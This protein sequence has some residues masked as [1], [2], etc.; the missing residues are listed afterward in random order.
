MRVGT[1]LAFGFLLLLLGRQ[2]SAAQS[3]GAPSRVISLNGEWQ[4]ALAH[5]PAEGEGMAHFYEPSF[6]AQAFRPIPVPSNWSLHGFEEPLY[7]QQYRENGVGHL[8]LPLD[9]EGFY[10]HRFTVPADIAKRR[11]VLHF[12]GV[13]DSAEVWLNGQPLGRHDSG[14][15]G[16]QFDIGNQLRP[17]AENTLAVRVRQRTKDSQLDI[18]DDWVL[19]GIFRDVTLEFTPSEGYIQRIETTTK[20]DHDYRDAVLNLRLFFGRLTNDPHPYQAHVTLADPSGHEVAHA[21]LAGAIQLCG[22]IVCGQDVPVAMPVTAPLHWTAETPNL[23]T[24]RVDLLLDGQVVHTR[25]EQVGFREVSWAGGVL[26]VNGQAIKIRGVG[27]H[28]EHPDVGRATTR[29]QWLQ[30]I[31]MMKAGNINAVRTTHYPPAEGFVKLCDEMGLYVLE[32]IPLGFGGDLLLDES[33]AGPVLLRAR[34][35]LRRDVNRP[36]VIMW[37]LGNEDPLTDIHLTAARYIKG[38][39]PT[40][41]VLMPWRADETLPV[42]LDIRAPHYK[43]AEEYDRMAAASDRPVVSTEYSHAL[44]DHDFGGLADRWEAITRHAAGAGG[45]IW[46]WQDQG[47]RRNTVGKT[48]LDPV[49]D[50]G[51]YLAVGSEFVRHDQLGPDQI[52]DSHGVFGSDGIVNPDRT[53][54]RDYWETK[55]VYAPVRVMAEELPFRPGQAFAPISIR[56]DYDFTDLHAVAIHWQVMQDDRELS[57]G[58][59]H[60]DAPPHTV[61]VLQ[62]PLAAM[63]G[64]EPGAYSI[65][66]SFRHPDGTEITARSVHLRTPPRAVPVASGQR[67]RVVTDGPAVTVSAGNV[68]YRFDARTGQLGGIAAGGTPLVTGARLSIWRPLSFSETRLFR[69]GD[70]KQLPLVPD[71]GRYQASARSWTVTEADDG[72]HIAADLEQR[73]DDRNGFAARVDYHVDGDGALHVGYVITPHIE[74]KWLPEVGLRLDPAPGLDAMRWAGLGP[75][76]SYPDEHAAAR[77]GIWSARQGTEDAAGVKSGVE[78]AELKAASGPSLRITGA[79]YV[80]LDRV[81]DGAGALHVLSSMVGRS[82]KFKRPERLEDRLDLSEGSSFTGGFTVSVGR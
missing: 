59:A 4:F 6:D 50:L 35:V 52:M 55:A 61:G 79:P 63:G 15:T 21:E 14:F 60:V 32:E 27:R 25:T 9:S 34:E 24:L 7:T 10:L 78:W 40:R 56:N 57:A 8:P 46:H 42:E 38:A 58:D 67:P 36:S 45:F 22:F 1:C 77:F 81:S 68:S 29:E 39:D 49:A 47:L 48:V 70:D 30:D 75:I 43:T 54:Q 17:G 3:E 74:F 33:L 72:V 18:N 80:E 11:A 51:K 44:G 13:W 82:T 31:R 19:P 12:D 23:Y 76:D 73:I 71:L 69:G 41:P 20:F 65:Q 5:N 62:V 53:P 26:R 64:A 2:P 66:L 37:S 28:D 16:F